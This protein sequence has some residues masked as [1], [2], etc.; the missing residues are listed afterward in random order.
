VSCSKEAMCRAVRVVRS[1]EMGYL[2][3]LKHF[4]APRGTLGM[5]VKDISR[6]TEELVNLHLER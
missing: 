4:S 6:S 2:R 3:A 5:Y 1:E